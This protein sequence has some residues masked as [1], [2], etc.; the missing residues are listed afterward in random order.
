ME[1]KSE[2]PF[3]IHLLDEE[4]KAAYFEWEKLFEICHNPPPENLEIGTIIMPTGYWMDRAPASLTLFKERFLKQDSSPH[5]VVTGKHSHPD[6]LRGGAG[7]S[8]VIRAMNIYGK[9]TPKMKQNLI[10]DDYAENT[11]MQALNIS[12]ALAWRH[13]SEP[14]VV[15]VSAEHLPRLYSTF[16]AT[17]LEIENPILE[18]RLYSIAVFGDWE[19]DIPKENRGKRYEQIPAE[20]NR[21]PG[22]RAKGDV[23]TEEELIRYVSWLKTNIYA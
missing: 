11:K 23:A 2:N 3:P 4:Q 12:A 18:T 9:L 1:T 16:I 7:A 8:K 6:L 19:S 14:L 10:P 20:I 5:L 15:V 21:F 13:I 22:Y 17:I